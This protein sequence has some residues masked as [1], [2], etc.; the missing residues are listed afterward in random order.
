[1]LLVGPQFLARIE[2]WQTLEVPGN[3]TSSITGWIFVQCC[4]YLFFHFWN[5][6]VIFWKN[7]MYHNV[8]QC[9]TIYHN[10]LQCITMYLNVRMYHKNVSEKCI[11][12]MH[13]KNASQK[14]ITEMYHRNVSQKC[15]TKMY[16]KNVSQYI[17]IYHI[18]LHKKEKMNHKNVSQKCIT[19]M[20]RKNASQKC[21]TK[22]Y[23]NESQYIAIYHNVSQSIILMMSTFRTLDFRDA[24]K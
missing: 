4:A 19:K 12:K 6:E 9:I 17:I 18:V 23:H 15:F 5:I 16:H 13:H 24:E 21:I 1:M 11:T 8:S 3:W 20:Y 10:T 22:I 7:A 2:Y 14:C